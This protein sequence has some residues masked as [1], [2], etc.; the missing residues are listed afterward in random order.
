MLKIRKHQEVS[1]DC[2]NWAMVSKD[3]HCVL[4]KPEQANE[5]LE[6]AEM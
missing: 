5:L 3:A 4:Q 1:S 6:R 2:C